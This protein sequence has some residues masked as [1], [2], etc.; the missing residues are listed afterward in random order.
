MTNEEAIEVLVN[1]R[2]TY[3]SGAIGYKEDEALDVAIKA[4]GAKDTN[5]PTSSALD[6]IHNV[7]RDDAYR[8]WYEQ[9][10]ADAEK[11]MHDNFMQYRMPEPWK[12]E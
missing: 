2:Y 1:L 10:K 7:V 11:E 5:V 4:L 8:R 9:G 6:H 3:D 12:G